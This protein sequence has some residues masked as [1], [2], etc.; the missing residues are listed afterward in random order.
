M[1]TG[2]AHIPETGSP[3]RSDRR[4]AWLIVLAVVATLSVAFALLLSYAVTQQNG[5]DLTSAQGWA[6]VTLVSL[7]PGFLVAATVWFIWWPPASRAPWLLLLAPLCVAVVMAGV[8]GAAVLGGR[9]YDEDRATIAAAC[10]AHDVDVLT[11]FGIYGGE[12]G[13]AQGSTDGTCGAWLIFPGEDGRGVMTAVTAGMEADGWFTTDTAWN[14]KTFT[15]GSEVV[16]VTH[17][18]SSEGST[19]ILVTAVDPR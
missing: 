8:A 2:T 12:F 10:T 7:V 13:G 11:G 18:R 9:A 6:L 16:H 4:T 3:T 14:S 5:A 15:R 19:G 1:S 17:Q